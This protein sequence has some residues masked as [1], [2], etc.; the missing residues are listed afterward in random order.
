[1]WLAFSLLVLTTRG[2]LINVP[3]FY[4]LNGYLEILV[5]GMLNEQQYWAI[6]ITETL[7]IKPKVPGC[8][9]KG[10]HPRD[11]PLTATHNPVTSPRISG[12]AR[13]LE[14]FTPR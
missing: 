8:K 9:P 14:K 10:I 1:M 12:I 7:T 2:F 4:S 13:K 11:H 3:L 6:T 5:L